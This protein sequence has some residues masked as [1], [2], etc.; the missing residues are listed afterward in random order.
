MPNEDNKWLSF[1]NYYRKK[2]VPFIVYADL[3]CTLEKMEMN[4]KT[5]SYI[6]Q[7]YRVFSLAYYV[8]CSYDNSLCMYRFRRER[9]RRMVRQGT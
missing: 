4:M 3:E 1:N 7:Q 8:Y 2:L 9:L 6:Y 5:S